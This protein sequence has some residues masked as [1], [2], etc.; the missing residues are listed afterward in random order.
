MHIVALLF[1]HAYC[2]GETFRVLGRLGEI[3]SLVS[4][5]VYVL[6]LTATA[7]RKLRVDVTQI[8]GLQNE[9]DV[10]ISI[11]PSKANIIYAIAEFT[12]KPHTFGPMLSQLKRQR[13]QFPRT[14]V[15][16]RRY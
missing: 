15:Y 16:C 1:Y 12:T 3:R 13:S 6:A 9:V 2:R 4:S 14:I 11:S 7:S 8:L 10:V 5:S